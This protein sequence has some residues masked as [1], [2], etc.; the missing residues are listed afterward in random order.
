[1]T[2]LEFIKNNP[3]AALIAAVIFFTFLFFPFIVVSLLVIA[4]IY[5]T[6]IKK[7][8]TKPTPVK[9]SR[10]TPSI[11]SS[12]N[13]DRWTTTRYH[14]YLQTPEW[15]SLVSKIKSRDRVCQL[16]G[17]TDN[18]EV[19]HITYDRLG[20]EDLSDLVLLSRSAHQFVHD[21]YGS[22]SRNNTY[23]IDSLKG[24]I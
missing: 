20:N 22:Y 14:A 3:V 4:W 10:T 17:A 9:P 16:T 18:L 12:P 15:K 8:S 23:P 6:F 13:L 1:M 11:Y 5:E 2:K 21:Y 24:L 19:H 7:S